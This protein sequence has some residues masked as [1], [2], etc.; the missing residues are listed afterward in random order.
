MTPTNIAH[1]S[2]LE[3]CQ[4]NGHILK[5]ITFSMTI[6]IYTLVVISPNPF[7]TLCR[8]FIMII[9]DYIAL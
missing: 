9:T 2:I 6:I 7:C 4:T 3:A 5:N 8:G 1:M